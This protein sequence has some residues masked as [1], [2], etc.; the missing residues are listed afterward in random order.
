MPSFGWALVPPLGTG[1]SRR[2]PDGA[3]RPSL[4]S[5]QE[6]VQPLHNLDPW[7]VLLDCL[8]SAT[9]HVKQNCSPPQVGLARV[10]W[11]AIPVPNT[12]NP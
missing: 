1:T 8:G 5:R 10:S 6:E 11:I 12:L 4:S 9:P 3:L 2:Q 7:V